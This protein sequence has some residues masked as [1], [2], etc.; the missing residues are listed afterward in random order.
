MTHQK[1]LDSTSGTK[2]KICK[3]IGRTQENVIDEAEMKKQN[4]ENTHTHTIH[5]IPN[6]FYIVLM[7]Y[8]NEI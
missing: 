2:R 7:I 1:V 5:N 3:R 6:N 8:F 4:G